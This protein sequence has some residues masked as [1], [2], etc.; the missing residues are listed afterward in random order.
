MRLA[1]LSFV[2]AGIVA[3]PIGAHSSGPLTAGGRVWLHAHNCY[4]DEGRGADRLARA[5]A[6]ARGPVAIEQDVAWDS[7]RRQSVL[8]HDTALDG[9]ELTLDEHFFHAVAPVLDRALAAGPSPEWPIMVLHLDFKSNEPEH[10]AAIWSLLGTYERWLTTAPRVT[11]GAAVQP[12][13]PGPLLVLTEQGN[14]Q[15]AV[16]HDLVPV[17]GR[18]RIFGTVPAPSRLEDDTP[19]VRFAAAISAAPEVL[20]P[21]GATNYRRWSNFA[22]D[23]VELGGQPRAGDWTPADR[24]RLDD[25]VGRAH[26]LSLWVRFYTLNGHGPNSEGWTNSYN[27]GSLEA[28]E[29]RWRA[30]IDAGVDFIATDQYE[31]F[32]TVRREPLALAGRRQHRPDPAP[33]GGAYASDGVR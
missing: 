24:A 10:H 6:A 8:S 13:T 29:P 28:V 19:A 26:S 32:A 16:F 7:R 33:T 1:V 30:A 21:T 4:P 25:V 15:E 23:V 11:D 20:I 9:T 17:G 31:A 22:W 2:V 12:F 14:G 5:L 3:V 27:F 18:L